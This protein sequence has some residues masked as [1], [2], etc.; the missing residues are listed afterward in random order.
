M[1]KLWKNEAGYVITLIRNGARTK[2]EVRDGSGGSVLYHEF[3]YWQQAQAEREADALVALAHAREARSD[4]G[5][6]L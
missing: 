1:S 6:L 2:L 4:V 3:E 5:S